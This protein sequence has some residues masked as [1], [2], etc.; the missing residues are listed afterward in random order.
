MTVY[1]DH[2]RYRISQNTANTL[3]TLAEKC[4][5][6]GYQEIFRELPCRRFSGGELHSRGRWLVKELKKGWII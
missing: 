4:G 1:F 5:E 3:I 6:S 2:L